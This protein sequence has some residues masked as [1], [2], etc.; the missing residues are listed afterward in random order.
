MTHTFYS[1]D[2]LAKAAATCE[3][4]TCWLD[5]AR[6]PKDSSLNEFIDGPI[7]MGS[8]GE[9]FSPLMYVLP[10]TYRVKREPSSP[11]DSMI[12]VPYATPTQITVVS[13]DWMGL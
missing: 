8:V 9:G 6:V 5:F 3:Y 4:D 2:P 13:S 10:Q 11:Y 1:Y 12:F 7:M